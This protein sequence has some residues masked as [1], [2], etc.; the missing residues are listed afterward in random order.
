MAVSGVIIGPLAEDSDDSVSAALTAG[1]GTLHVDTTNLP[2]DVSVGGDDSAS[3]TVS[4]NAADVNSVL[5]SLS[6]TP[7]AEYEGNDTLSL[8]VSSTDGANTYDH[9]DWAGPTLTCASA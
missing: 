5:Q 7:T 3:L 4:G 2:A 6:Y 1:Q 9:S 8:S